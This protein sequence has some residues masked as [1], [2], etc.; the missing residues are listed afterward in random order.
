MTQP[1]YTYDIMW[2]HTTPLLYDTVRMTKVWF[3]LDLQL[4]KD[5]PYQ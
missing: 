3:W 4:E 1:L 2:R 5:I